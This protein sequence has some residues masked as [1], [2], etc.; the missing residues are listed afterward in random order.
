MEHILPHG[1]SFF[2]LLGA[3]T[4]YICLLDCWKGERYGGGYFVGEFFCTAV[5]LALDCS[6]NVVRQPLIKAC[7]LFGN[8][9]IRVAWRNVRSCLISGD[10]E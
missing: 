5:I 9:G 8:V 3:P 10:G 6:R 4:G 7:N 1:S 2:G